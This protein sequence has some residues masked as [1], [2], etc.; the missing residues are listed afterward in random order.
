M[1]KVPGGV[2]ATLTLAFAFS[3]DFIDLD[4]GD[5][6]ECMHARKS[7][8]KEKKR[9]VCD[10]QPAFF[11]VCQALCIASALYTQGIL[12]FKVPSGMLSVPEFAIF[13]I[14]S[15]TSAID[16]VSTLAV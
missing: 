13:A 12:E 7:Q 11:V 2:W 14:T 16:A 3:K 15:L 6:F 10:R 9:G 5:I 8:K 1:G 4:L